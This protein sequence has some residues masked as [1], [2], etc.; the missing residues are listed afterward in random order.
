MPF[1]VAVSD[2]IKRR[3]DLYG[4]ERYLAFTRA[5]ADVV[6]GRAEGRQV[7]TSA[8]NQRAM[9][10]LKQ[11][12]Y[13]LYYSLDPAVGPPSLV[14]EEFLTAAEG[15]LILDTFAEGRD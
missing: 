12:D 15:E 10:A 6:K 8:R 4:D 5:V 1:Q 13:T 7:H 9:Y 3:L 2:A 14:I 11:G